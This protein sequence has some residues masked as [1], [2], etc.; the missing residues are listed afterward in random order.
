M[1]I[2]NIDH[3]DAIQISRIKRIKRPHLALAQRLRL[4]GRASFSTSGIEP[5]NADIC[6]TLAD[7]T[8]INN[9]DDIKPDSNRDRR[10][11]HAQERACARCVLR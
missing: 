1:E 2:P 3:R 11:T 9:H 7:S 8:L 10:R 6:R 4:I 5:R